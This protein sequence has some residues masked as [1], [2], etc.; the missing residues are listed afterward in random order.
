MFQFLGQRLQTL[1]DLA[2]FQHPV[3]RPRPGRRTHQLQIIDDDQRQALGPLQ[4]PA[5]R[6]QHRHADRRRVVDLQRQRADLARRPPRTCRNPSARYRRGECGRRKCALPRSA[7][8][9][10]AVPR[11]FPARRSRPAVSAARSGPSARAC[12]SSDFRRAERDLGGQ[13]GFAHAGTA[14]QDQQIGRVQAAQFAV[15]IAQAGGQ[16]GDVA[17]LVETP[18]RRP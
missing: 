15:D 3:F 13:R 17:G 6:A 14:R 12:S 4:P 10:R 7:V 11:S 18:A 5:A 2:D 16:A 1:G 9:W 8:V